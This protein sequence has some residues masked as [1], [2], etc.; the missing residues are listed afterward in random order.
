[1]ARSGAQLQEVT[2][3]PVIFNLKSQLAMQQAKLS[4][5]RN[6]LGESHPQLQELTANINELSARIAQ[7]TRTL[8]GG[9]QATNQINQSR[10]K[11][12]ETAVAEQR[13]KVLK[14]KADRD[15]AAVLQR[16]VENAQRAYEAVV[17]RA[18]QTGLEAQTQQSNVSILNPAPLPIDPAF[19]K[20]LLNTVLSVF[21]G[22]LLALATALLMEVM[23]R[24]MRSPADVVALAGLTVIGS[25]PRANT[26]K[27]KSRVRGPLLAG[28]RKDEKGESPAQLPAPE[29]QS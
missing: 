23:D 1:V 13:V 7:E 11:Q 14:M 24:R 29:A 12:I 3:N 27:L 10:V 17:N 9:V 28:A 25:L 5:A 19:P 2:S 20:L 16:D 6:R 15:E 8:T 18:N 21:V 4:E 22:G 26:K